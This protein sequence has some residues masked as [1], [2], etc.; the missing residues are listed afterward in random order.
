MPASTAISA[1]TIISSISENPFR[2]GGVM[3]LLP[4]K[5]CSAWHA[6]VSGGFLEGVSHFATRHLHIRACA[7]RRE[8]STAFSRGVVACDVAGIARA[9][10]CRFIT[11]YRSMSPTGAGHGTCLATGWGCTSWTCSFPPACS[12]LSCASLPV[13]FA[14][15]SERILAAGE[16]TRTVVL[17]AQKVEELR[18]EPFPAPGRSSR[19]TCSMPPAGSSTPRGPRRRSSGCGAPNRSPPRPT[20]QSSSRLSWRRITAPRG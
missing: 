12:P 1:T 17:A 15:R 14:G 3:H 20:R 10:L 2:R 16:T 6:A 18:S 5:M 4:D 11:P 8:C 7:T 9:T 19:P 13:A